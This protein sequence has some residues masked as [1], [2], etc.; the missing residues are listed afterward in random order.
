MRKL[1]PVLVVVVIG[2]FVALNLFGGSPGTPIDQDNTEI[3]EETPEERGHLLTKI[4]QRFPK[5]L[6]KKP[7]TSLNQHQLK[8]KKRKCTF[9]LVDT[10][11]F[12]MI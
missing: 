1:V 6:L 8:N 9:P 2:L 10:P 12:R 4:I 5:K 11:R 3:P 7:R